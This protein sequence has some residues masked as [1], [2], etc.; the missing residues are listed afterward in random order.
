VL[1]LPMPDADTATT[2]AED[3]DVDQNRAVRSPRPVTSEICRHVHLTFWNWY[4]LI[5]LMIDPVTAP[6]VVFGDSVVGQWAAD[7]VQ[8]GDEKHLYLL[9]HVWHMRTS[10]PLLK[11]DLYNHIVE[12]WD[13]DPRQC[14]FKHPHESL[15]DFGVWDFTIGAMLLTLGSIFVSVFQGYI[16]ATSGWICAILLVIANIAIGALMVVRTIRA[17][18]RY[19]PNFPDFWVTGGPTTRGVGDEVVARRLGNR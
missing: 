4:C 11:E 15:R 19:F 16:S 3:D 17:I 1:C 18:R 9:M 8:R 2:T 14:A 12:L 7:V 10:D 6:G 13:G 5:R